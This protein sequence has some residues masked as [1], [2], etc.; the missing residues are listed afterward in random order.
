MQC[1]FGLLAMVAG[2]IIECYILVDGVK[3]RKVLFSAVTGTNIVNPTW[4]IR[5]GSTYS[6]GIRHNNA[7][8]KSLTTFSDATM[9][10]TSAE[11]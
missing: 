9:T 8:S 1:N 4:T 2:D 5:S 3:N 7:G 10:V 6:V 11:N